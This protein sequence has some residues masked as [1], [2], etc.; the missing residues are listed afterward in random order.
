MKKSSII[1]EK[2][3]CE[4]ISAYEIL[5]ENRKYPLLHLV[6]DYVSI[7]KSARDYAASEEGLRYSKVE[8]FVINSLAHKLL[9]N[10]YMKVNKPSVPTRF[11]RNKEDAEEWLAEFL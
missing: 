1:G 5:L 10:F 9:A 7:D 3:A 2:E 8:A 11:F 6:E 4:V